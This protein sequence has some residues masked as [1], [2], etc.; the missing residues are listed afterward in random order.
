[1]A[2]PPSD[3]LVNWYA[4]PPAVCGEVALTDVLEPAIVVTLNGV[5]NTCPPTPIESAAT[6]GRDGL[7]TAMVF[8]AG[9]GK[10]SVAGQ[11]IGDD[12]NF[13]SLNTTDNWAFMV[14][15]VVMAGAGWLMTSLTPDPRIVAMVQVATAL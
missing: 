6:T 9:N 13:L 3:Q 2:A 8:A 5:T 15:G 11:N 4:S 7:G 12:A 1:M 14:M 10:L